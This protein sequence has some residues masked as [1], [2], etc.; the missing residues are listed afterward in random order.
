MGEKREI[1]QLVKKCCI[2]SFRVTLFYCEVVPNFPFRKIVQNAY[3]AESKGCV[4]IVLI[5]LNC[6]YSDI[7]LQ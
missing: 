5:M 2:L 1:L 3:C 6:V 7:D 4:L